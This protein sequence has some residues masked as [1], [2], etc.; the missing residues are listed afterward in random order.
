MILPLGNWTFVLDAGEMGSSTEAREINSSSVWDLELLVYPEG[1]STVIIDF[2]IDHERDN[3]ASNG[4][5][6]TYPF[7]VYSLEANGAGYEV[8]VDGDEWVSTGRAEVSL[9]PG[10]Y[11]IVVERANASADEPFDT[12]YDLNDVFQ[13]GMDSSTVERSVGFEPLWLVNISF[14]NESGS[15]LTNHEVMFVDSDNGWIQTFLTDEEGRVVEY[16]LEGDWIVI[17][18]EFETSSDVF[19][20]L[21][22]QE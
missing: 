19:E 13:V 17:V 14:S 11:R 15:L 4:T 22:R 7:S 1:N 2:F 5:A 18:K 6:V 10:R 12:L 9:E 21:R 8:T 3:N 16:L 20:G